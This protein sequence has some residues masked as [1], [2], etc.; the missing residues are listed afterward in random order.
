MPSPERIFGIVPWP[1]YIRCPGRE[2]RRSP[3]MALVRGSAQRSLHDDLAHALVFTQVETGDVALGLEQ[4][5]D[6]MLELG[7]GG[8]H[9]RVARHDG[10][11]NS[12]QEVGDGISH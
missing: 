3:V 5:G 10:V 12:G 4:L 7:R 1:T 11:A 8:D 6:A 2:R 9:L